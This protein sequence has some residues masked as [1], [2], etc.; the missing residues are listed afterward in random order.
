MCG[1]PISQSRPK[2]YRGDSL[3]RRI[4]GG[5]KIKRGKLPGV[6]SQGDDLSL[7]EIGVPSN[8]VPKRIRRWDLHFHRCQHWSWKR[9]VHALSAD[10]AIVELSISL[11]TVLTLK[12]ARFV[13]EIAAIY[14]LKNNLE[15]DAFEKGTSSEIPGVVKVSENE[16]HSLAYHAFLTKAL[17]AR[18]GPMVAKPFTAAGV[19]PINT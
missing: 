2:D 12:H 7:Q 14:N 8:L 9:R 17:G 6:E 5:H 15:P 16:A 4:A 3:E 10:S 19:R 1:A 13:H 11:R 18:P